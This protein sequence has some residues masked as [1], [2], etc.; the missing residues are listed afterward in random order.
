VS[1]GAYDTPCSPD[2]KEA[3]LML[4]PAMT[5]NV[6]VPDVPLALLLSVAVTVNG[7]DPAAV[8]V[9]LSTPAELSVSPSRLPLDVHVQHVASSSPSVAMN[10]CAG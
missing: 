10:V 7:K 1:F 2:G 4:G 6:S 5:V 8:G 3:G 9:P